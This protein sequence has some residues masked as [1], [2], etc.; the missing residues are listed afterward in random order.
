MH[1]ADAAYQGRAGELVDLM[2]K[3]GRTEASREGI[4]AHLLAFTGNYIGRRTYMMIGDTTHYPLVWPLIIGDTAAGKGTS[5]APVRRCFS[6]LDETYSTINIE[7]GLGSGEG[8][9]ERLSPK[10]DEDGNTVYPDPRL[11]VIEQEFT[12]VLR[13]GNREGSVL[14]QTLQNAWDGAPLGSLNRSTNALRAPEHH[15]TVVGHITPRGFESEVKPSDLSNGFINRL[16]PIKVHTQA[17][18]SRPAGM[19]SSDLDSAVAILRDSFSAAPH[20][21]HSHTDSYWQ[22]WDR[23][24]EFYRVSGD[25]QTAEAL[26]RARPQVHRVAMVYALLDGAQQIG[27][28]HLEAAR[29]LVDYSMWTVRDQFTDREVDRMAKVRA[30]VE[31]NGPGTSRDVRRAAWGG[32]H[33]SSPNARDWFDSVVE[34]GELVPFSGEWNSPR[35]VP[36]REANDANRGIHAA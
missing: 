34:R 4:L 12:S 9:I 13:K 27:V 18:V 33:A 30:W 20:G 6:R 10:D 14:A 32:R 7:P 19:S 17:A 8:L 16:L 23:T 2:H 1:L 21:E 29:A 5:L 36:G 28:P 35:W 3:P 22:T 26:G 31:K 24:H 15:V 11:I 25:D